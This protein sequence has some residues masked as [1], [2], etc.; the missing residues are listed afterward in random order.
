MADDIKV[1]N[2]SDLLR[3]VKLQFQG[4]GPPNDLPATTAKGGARAPEA[5]AAGPGAAKP[6]GKDILAPSPCSAAADGGPDAPASLLEGVAASLTEQYQASEWLVPPGQPNDWRFMLAVCRAALVAWFNPVSTLPERLKLVEAVGRAFGLDEHAL[7]Q[8]VAESL[9]TNAKVPQQLALQHTALDNNAFAVRQEA[10]PPERE[11]KAAY[12]AFRREAMLEAE[13]LLQQQLGLPEFNGML[14]VEVVGA[15]GLKLKRGRTGSKQLLPY[16]AVWLGDKSGSRRGEKQFTKVADDP[17][18]PIWTQQLPPL[19]VPNPELELVVQVRCSQ[20]GSRPSRMDP[21]LGRVAVR[22]AGLA[23]GLTQQVDLL[24]YGQ[25]Q[26]QGGK[27]GGGGAGGGFLC[28]C[29]SGGGKGAVKEPDTAVAARTGSA[30][31]LDDPEGA[32]VVFDPSTSLTSGANDRQQAGRLT[33]MLRY[34]PERRERVR[35]PAGPSVQAA[36]GTHPNNRHQRTQS[37]PDGPQPGGGAARNQYRG[38]NNAA[39]ANTGNGSGMAGT[40]EDDT[41]VKGGGAGGGGGGAVGAS[42]GLSSRL[43]DLA[44]AVGSQ[45]DALHS[46]LPHSMRRVRKLDSRK[47]D[48]LAVMDP[49]ADFHATFRKLAAALMA[50][51]A[52]RAG[53]AAALQAVPDPDI[54]LTALGS[55]GQALE[56]MGLEALLARFLPRALG[57]TG[58]SLLLLFA[59]LFR[60]RTATQQLA[61]L[62]ALLAEGAWEPDSSGYLTLLRKLWEPVLLWNS[63]GQLTLVETEGLSGVNAAFL[64]RVCPLLADH[65][66]QLPGEKAVP[67]MVLLIEMAGWAVTGDPRRRSCTAALP[68]TSA[69]AGSAASASAAPSAASLHLLIEHLQ[70][71]GSAAAACTSALRPTHDSLPADVGALSREAQRALEQLE[72]DLRLQAEIPGL[73][74]LTRTNCRVRYDALADALETLFMYRPGSC[75]AAATALWP[76]E[77]AVTALHSLMTR[78]RFARQAHEVA[79]T[80]GKGA[81]SNRRRHSGGDCTTAS[82]TPRSR[83]GRGLSDEDGDD[84]D[85]S[86]VSVGDRGAGGAGPQQRRRRSDGSE[87]AAD[88]G[89]DED[90]DEGGGGSAV[91]LFDF[92]AAMAEAMAEWAELGGEDLKRQ[93]MRLLERDPLWPP[94][95]PL[96]K[97]QPKGPGGGNG[98]GGG[99]QSSAPEGADGSDGRAAGLGGGGGGAGR[100]LVGKALLS[101]GAGE[102]AVELFRMLQVYLDVS[103]ERALGGGELRPALMGPSI[104]SAVVSCVRIY[105]HHCMRAWEEITISRALPSDGPGGGAA[106]AAGGHRHARTISDRFMYAIGVTNLASPAPPLPSSAV[107]ANAGGLGSYAATLAAAGPSAPNSH[108]HAAAAALNHAAINGLM[109]G[110]DRSCAAAV[111]VAGGRPHAAPSMPE[112]GV[113]PAAGPGAGSAA[114]GT[115]GASGGSAVVASTSQ[116]QAPQHRRGAHRRAATATDVDGLGGSHLGA[117]AGRGG[118][119]A[120]ATLAAGAPGTPVGSTLPPATALALASEPGLVACGPLVMVRN[121]IAAVAEGAEALE[122]TLGLLA[123]RPPLVASK[124][125]SQPQKRSPAAAASPASGPP[126]PAPPSPAFLA[127]ATAEL[128]HAVGLAAEQCLTSYHLSLRASLLRGL[129]AAF[130]P[131]GTRPPSRKALEGL[132]SALHEELL[133]VSRGVKQ[134]AVAGAMVGTAWEAA[135]RCVWALVLHQA[136]FRPIVEEEADVL[137]ELL[138]SL[139]DMFGEVVSEQL[140]QRDTPA[141]RAAAAKQKNAAA[142]SGTTAGANRGLGGSGGGG[143]GSSSSSSLLPEVL[144]SADSR[145]A[146]TA[147]PSALLQCVAA[148]TQDLK[149]MYTA[150]MSCLQKLDDTYADEDGGPTGH[151]VTLLDLLRLLRQRRRTDPAA[152]AFVTEQLRLASSNVMQV[153]FGLRSGERLIATASCYLTP[154]AGAIGQSAGAGTGLPV[155]TGPAPGVPGSGGVYGREGWLY[156]TPR[157]LGFSTLLAGDLKG[158]T[159]V[160]SHIKLRTVREVTRGDGADTLLVWTHGGDLFHLYGFAAG[161]RDRLCNLINGTPAVGRLPHL[162]RLSPAVG[163]AVGSG[164]VSGHGS[165]RRS[166]GGQA[167][168][169]IA[170]AVAASA[171]SA[172]GVTP[173]GLATPPLGLP[174]P[175]SQASNLAAAIMSAFTSSSAAAAPQATAS[176]ANLPAPAAGGGPLARVSGRAVR[177]AGS[178]GAAEVAAAAASTAAS[179]QVA[180]SWPGE[181]VSLPLLSAPCHLVNVLRNKDGLLHLYADRL[182]FVC[183]ADP[184]VS[185]SMSLSAINNVSQRPAG[186]GGGSVL[187]LVLEG[188]KTP[189]VFGGI[190]DTLLAALKQNISELCFANG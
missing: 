74:P 124:A 142:A 114:L 144:L 120:G 88:D 173:S 99:P 96:Q 72:Q 167:P 136:G 84:S 105:L 8:L 53:G 118:N 93:L 90:D 51:A 98:V 109:Q 172:G 32:R 122:E 43:Q 161:E 83:G 23:P 131:A 66:Q 7:E 177:D 130:D 54:P 56:D 158:T 139:Q 13:H 171:G 40:T 29:F 5:P 189:V 121:T 150:Q 108:P 12:Q 46:P 117:A 57:P 3:G 159:D 162:S 182:D 164:G 126:P 188:D 133:G 169:T 44:V 104:C 181:S 1:I 127:R 100:G 15:T 6:P 2:A 14:L 103:V 156:V 123:P 26:A 61:L 116:Q 190:G 168:T 163:G 91:V 37:A 33:L 21:L 30:E 28:G 157:V 69:P 110:A 59:K 152:N 151:Q 135:V 185:R 42:S 36:A 94:P 22:L 85:V 81:A 48:P 20:D 19:P 184:G 106:A 17:E 71:A 174:K 67:C 146:G 155:T 50:L 153:L 35:K 70:R 138:I 77:V 62:Q 31:Q 24:L 39:T 9:I 38:G 102:S 149:D 107:A 112:Y 82:S 75:K 65:Y 79:S 68:A 147:Y 128:R 134:V 47:V 86:P 63:S 183:S 113:L 41:W 18:S 76:L 87:G 119:P 148:S 16:A 170:T 89:D 115:T 154:P 92:E 179:Q 80:S 141:T 11:G 165:P 125:P 143:E 137:R 64:R 176:A 52:D 27:G 145:A 45:L 132:L 129:L 25:R 10:F 140:V 186:W 78:H 34:V 166:N 175:P 60:V 55:L 160:T 4:H 73:R 58:L 187:V 101:S 95:A 97:G 49:G 180:P 111:A 178:A